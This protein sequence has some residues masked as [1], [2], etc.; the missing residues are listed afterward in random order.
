MSRFSYLNPL[1]WWKKEEPELFYPQHFIK[2][3]LNPIARMKGQSDNYN[4]LIQE[5]KNGVII[6]EMEYSLSI[7]DAYKKIYQI[8]IYE[9]TYIDDEDF[10]FDSFESPGIISYRK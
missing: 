3:I 1:N 8:P 2:I 4:R 9:E 7:I 6:K 10:E 5:I